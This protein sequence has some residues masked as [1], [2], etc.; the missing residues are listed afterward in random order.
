MCVCVCV[1]VIGGCGLHLFE[2]DSPPLPLILMLLFYFFFLALVS[3]KRLRY[4]AKRLTILTKTS[5]P[6]IWRTTV[7]I[8]IFVERILSTIRDSSLIIV[9]SRELRKAALRVL[10]IRMKC[11]R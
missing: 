7:F 8:R 3:M 1:A 11:F 5:L 6:S 2:N 9:Q 4:S 10:T